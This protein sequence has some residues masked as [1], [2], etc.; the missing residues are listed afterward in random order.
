L[1]SQA[2][3]SE[4]LSEDERL[5]PKVAEVEDEEDIVEYVDFAAWERDR[6]RELKIETNIPTSEDSKATE[7]QEETDPSVSSGARLAAVM[8][9]AQQLSEGLPSSAA[10]SDPVHNPNMPPSAPLVQSAASAKFPQSYTRQ[11]LSPSDPPHSIDPFGI[12]LLSSSRPVTPAS[13]AHSPRLQSALLPRP[14]HPPVIPESGALS[15]KGSNPHQHPSA[16]STASSLLSRSEIDVLAAATSSKPGAP[17]VSRAI[18]SFTVQSLHNPSPPLQSLQRQLQRTDQEQQQSLFPSSA[19]IPA[20]QVQLS[21]GYPRVLSPAYSAQIEALSPVFVATLPNTSTSLAVSAQAAQA[22]VQS[23]VQMVPSGDAVEDEVLEYQS[24]AYL[25]EALASC[26]ASATTA[27]IAQK[28]TKVSV[29]SRGQTGQGPTFAGCYAVIVDEK[30]KIADALAR[31]VARQLKKDLKERAGWGFGC[32]T[33]VSPI[34]QHLS[35]LYVL[36]APRRCK[37]SLHCSTL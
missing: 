32:V 19:S 31:K 35:S 28:Q 33:V 6:D 4:V 27:A 12:Q 11:S 22:S 17:L 25:S 30:A 37:R 1:Y 36:G 14:T 10:A 15:S 3:A 18:P 20:P 2:T 16:A 9:A 13:V 29:K 21:W 5:A 24:L 26:V 7:S 34:H 23:D 8:R